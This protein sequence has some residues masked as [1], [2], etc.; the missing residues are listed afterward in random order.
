MTPT[1]KFRWLIVPMTGVIGMEHPSAIPYTGMRVRVLQQWWN[2]YVPTIHYPNGV[3]DKDAYEVAGE[4]R[5]IPIEE[6]A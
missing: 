1:A 4:W 3:R 6:Q 2:A 5:D